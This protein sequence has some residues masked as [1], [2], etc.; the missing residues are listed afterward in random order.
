MSEAKTERVPI[1]FEKGLI[2][3]VDEYRF[4]NRISTRAKAIRELVKE[5]LNAKQTEKGGAPA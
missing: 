5:G 1:M 2:E 3:Q 4:G